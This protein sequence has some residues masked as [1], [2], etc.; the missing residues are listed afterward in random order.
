MV[1]KKNPN[2]LKI[3]QH[4]PIQGLSK[5]SQIGIF[6]FK[7]YVYMYHLATLYGWNCTYEGMHNPGTD[8]MIILKNS[9][10]Y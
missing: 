8:V 10:K 4:F 6:G 3:W 7:I 1:V 9:P 5:Y 2:D